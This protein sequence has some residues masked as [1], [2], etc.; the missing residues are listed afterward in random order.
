VRA[1]LAMPI[2]RLASGI[3]GRV[4]GRGTVLGPTNVLILV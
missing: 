3:Q 1:V 2:E 4:V